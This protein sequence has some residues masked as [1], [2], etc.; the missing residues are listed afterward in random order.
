[1]IARATSTEAAKPVPPDRP[2]GPRQAPTGVIWRDG[3][4]PAEIFCEL[5]GWRRAAFITAR[6]RGLKARIAGGRLYVTG[7][8]YFEYL[9]TCPE[10]GECGD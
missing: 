3:I 8:A 10:W 1:M 7:Q 6:N 5:V 4:Y 2:P 9:D